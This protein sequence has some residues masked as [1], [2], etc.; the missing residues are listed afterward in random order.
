MPQ[1]R[2]G[3]IPVFCSKPTTST[4]S[5]SRYS[6]RRRQ[7]YVLFRWLI[8]RYMQHALSLRFRQGQPKRRAKVPA[9]PP[10]D[11]FF[12]AAKGQTDRLPTGFLSSVH[13]ESPAGGIEAPSG[14]ARLFRDQFFNRSEL[15]THAE[16]LHCNFKLLYR[17]EGGR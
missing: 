7:G 16:K 2:Y 5:K 1:N 8:F 12:F 3:N 11:A 14:A 6:R 17:G 9:S 13:P 4:L 10:P 15:Y